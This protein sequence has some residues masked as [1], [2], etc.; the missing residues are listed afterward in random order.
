MGFMLENCTFCIKAATALWAKSS[1]PGTTGGCASITQGGFVLSLC[2]NF[3]LNPSSIL[4]GAVLHTLKQVH[5]RGDVPPERF[6]FPPPD[7]GKIWGN[8]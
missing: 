2:H 1:I 3:D 6:L 4:C 8:F 5:D 7:K